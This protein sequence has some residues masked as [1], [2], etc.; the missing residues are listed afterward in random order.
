MVLEFLNT[1][2]LVKS[3]V[4][5]AGN[6]AKG[7]NI[8]LWGK[9]DNIVKTGRNGPRTKMLLCTLEL[10]KPLISQNIT[11]RLTLRSK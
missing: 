4:S 8:L 5:V 6:G 7:A 2:E 9:L 1:I 11:A 3:K 10:A